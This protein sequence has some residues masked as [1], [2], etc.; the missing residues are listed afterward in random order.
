MEMA[1]DGERPRDKMSLH[2]VLVNAGRN[3]TFH[4]NNSHGNTFRPALLEVTGLLQRWLWFNACVCVM[5]GD[6]E[7]G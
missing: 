2:P 5:Q 4:R 3:G 1:C 7:R 6:L